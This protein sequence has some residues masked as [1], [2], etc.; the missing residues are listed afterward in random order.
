M[1][2]DQRASSSL[3]KGADAYVSYD[4]PAGPEHYKADGRLKTGFY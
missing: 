3:P 4:T 2:Q 1:K